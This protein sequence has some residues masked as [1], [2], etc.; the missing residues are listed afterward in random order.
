MWPQRRHCRRE[1]DCTGATV[2]E[3]EDAVAPLS[4]RKR[5]Q[6]QGRSYRGRNCSGASYRANGCGGVTGADKVTSAVQM[7]Q[8]KRPWRWHSDRKIYHSC[9]TLA[10]ALFNKNVLVKLLLPR[11]FILKGRTFLQEF[12]NFR[13]AE[14]AKTNSLSKTFAAAS[15]IQRKLVYKL[16]ESFLFSC[17]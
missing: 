17:N 3:K 13:S 16:W 2:A 4:P 14:S 15:L 8:E 6:K 1:R 7:S 12:V 9:A 5:S 10:R 11:W